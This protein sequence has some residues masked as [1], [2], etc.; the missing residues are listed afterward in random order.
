MHAS[1]SGSQAVALVVE[2][3]VAVDG[4]TVSV[5]SLAEIPHSGFSQ[6]GGREWEMR[7]KR[8]EEVND[9]R[10]KVQRRE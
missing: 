3:V 5:Q 7:G 4:P 2:L 10:A 6:T 1:R 8:P 9:E